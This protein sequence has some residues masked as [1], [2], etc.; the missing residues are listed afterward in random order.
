MKT[1]LSGFIA[2]LMITPGLLSAQQNPLVELL[3]SRTGQEGC[4][5]LDLTTNMFLSSGEEDEK[6]FDKSLHLTM[7]SLD[8]EM[9]GKGEA[10]RLHDD[11]IARIDK[12]SYRGLIEVRHDQENVEFLVKRDA[13]RVSE[14]IIIMLGDGETTLV[15]ASGNFD[16]IDLAKFGQL[17]NCKGL[18]ILGAL[19]EE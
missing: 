14:V 9:A 12:S 15:A 11:F 18:E 5:T 4:Y 13:D 6:E 19:C 10:K 1:L 8:E 17:K 3:E 16:L 7:V 2:V